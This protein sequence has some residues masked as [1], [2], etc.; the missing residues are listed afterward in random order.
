MRWIDA[1]RRDRARETPRYASD[2]QHE[3]LALVAPFMPAG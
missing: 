3:E 1:A 2:L